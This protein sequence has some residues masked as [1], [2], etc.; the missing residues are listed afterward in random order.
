[1]RSADSRATLNRA[2]EMRPRE[3]GGRVTEGPPKSRAGRRSSPSRRRWY[4]WCASTSPSTSG[5]SR[6]RWSTGPTGARLRRNNFGKLVGWSEAVA[7]VAA[8]G[9]HFHDLR[10]TGNAL[11]AKVPGT[12]IRDLM[13]RMGHDSAR[14]VLIYLHTAAGADRVI[15]EGLP[16]EFGD[17]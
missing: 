9:L 2:P 5:R 8:P 12:T 6:T 16:V 1:M 13:G 14:A 7:V 11:A 4:R 3:V 17:D 10:H 15:A